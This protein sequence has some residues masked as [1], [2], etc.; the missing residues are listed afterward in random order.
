MTWLASWAALPGFGFVAGLVLG[1]TAGVWLDHLLRRREAPDPAPEI[2]REALAREA[3]DLSR[4]IMELVADYQARL[5]AAWLDDCRATQGRRERQDEYEAMKFRAFCERYWPRYQD[6]LHRA[7]KAVSLNA[8][9]AWR[10]RGRLS[11]RDLGEM[12]AYL[13]KLAAELRYPH[14]DLPMHSPMQVEAE[15]QRTDASADA[16]RDGAAP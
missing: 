7:R 14:P 3:D 5:Q 12:A 11:G 4:K 6:I 9:N 15:R 10:V 2:D 13:T 1:L 16:R 8:D